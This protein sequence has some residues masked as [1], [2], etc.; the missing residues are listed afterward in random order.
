ML[1][2]TQNA[3]TPPTLPEVLSLPPH[4]DRPLPIAKGYPERAYVPPQ[5]RNW[6]RDMPN[7]K[8]PFYEAPVLKRNDRTVV[9]GG[10]ADPAEVSR[11]EFFL[12]SRTG[13]MRSY[14]GPI[15]HDPETGR[16]LNTLW[17][18]GIEGRGLLGKWGPNHAADAI[19]TRISPK[20]GLLEVL[21]I[22]RE[23]GA[24]AIPGGMVDAGETPL[25]T[26]CRE[27]A[28][29]ACVSPDSSEHALVYQGIGDGPRVTDNAWIETSAFHFHLSPISVAA[30]TQPRG[31]SD[32]LDAKWSTITP[33]LIRMMYANHGELLA[34]ALSQFRLHRPNLPFGVTTQLSEI[35]HVPVITNL[36]HINGR[37]GI[38]GGSFDPV[39][40]AHIEIAERAMAQHGLDAVIFMPTGHNPLKITGPIASPRERVQMLH[41]ALLTHPKMFVSPL[42]ARAPG[43]AYTVDTLERI[44]REIDSAHCALFFIMGAD[45]LQSLSRWKNY[46]RIPT[47]AEI[48]PIE[49]PGSRPLAC[50][51]ELFTRLSDELGSDVADQILRNIV[52]YEANSLSSTEVRARIMQGETRL[53]MPD[54]AY[55]YCVERKIYL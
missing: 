13:Y 45:S 3:P 55:R 54:T 37:I 7:Y 19:L 47:L 23:C 4:S 8:P 9:S 52:P 42:E 31:E 49:R 25:E 16:P 12:W 30:S 14:E 40:N 34:M 44:R 1:E 36:A 39:H 20:S 27:I 15:Y 46:T 6:Q 21:I 35:P 38:L 53:P 2:A 32:A 17:R 5:L 50:D 22:Q 51:K 33:D 24:W 43:V 41:H 28:E 11:D 29:E 18:T 48:V 10:W 26:A